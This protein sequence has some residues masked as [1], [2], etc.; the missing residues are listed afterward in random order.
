MK[1][2]ILWLLGALGASLCSGLVENELSKLKTLLARTARESENM[3]FH[4]VAEM[5]K[6]VAHI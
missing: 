3:F 5:L 1:P 4:K 2:I 6:I